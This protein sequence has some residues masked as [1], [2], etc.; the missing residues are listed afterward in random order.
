MAKSLIDA[1]AETEDKATPFQI[2][3]VSYNYEKQKGGETIEL[4]KAIRT[5]AKYTLEN[6]DMIAVTQ[7]ANDH[8]YPVHIHL[9]CE[10]NNQPIF[11]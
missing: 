2:K 10:I 5:G 9:I 6:N 3:F 4:T 1:L 8:P 11:L 7:N